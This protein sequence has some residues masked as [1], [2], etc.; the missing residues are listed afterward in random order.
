MTAGRRPAP[1]D[2]GSES[3]PRPMGASGTLPTSNGRRGSVTV[4]CQAADGKGSGSGAR[5]GRSPERSP[6]LRGGSSREAPQY[7][8]KRVPATQCAWHRPQVTTL[9]GV[10]PDAAMS[11]TGAPTMR[12]PSNGVE[13]LGAGGTAGGAGRGGSGAGRGAAASGEACWS[14]VPHVTQKRY[15]GGLGELHSTQSVTEG[16]EGG[17][18]GSGSAATGA[19]GAKVKAG[20]AG[21]DRRP[22]DGGP[23]GELPRPESGAGSAAWATGW[24]FG[25]P[26]GGVGAT[27]RCCRRRRPQS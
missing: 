17:R 14:E 18:G 9:A 26:L 23:D 24:N 2:D 25:I 16:G 19:A 20:A 7:L 8:Q 4:L 22:G 10:V 13:A 21:R 11:R 27:P 5:A 1:E 3:G 12:S 15:A 6:G